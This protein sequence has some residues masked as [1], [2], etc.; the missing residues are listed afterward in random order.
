MGPWIWIIVGLVMVWAGATNRARP[1][2]S[3]ALGKA[4]PNSAGGSAG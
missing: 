4:S 2:I 3:A 1:L